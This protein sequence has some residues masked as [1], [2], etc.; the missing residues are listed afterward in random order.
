MKTS[1]HIK[2][3]LGIA[4]GVIGGIGSFFFFGE[5]AYLSAFIHYVTQP[6]GQ[7]FIRLL[8]MLVIP[9]IFSALALGV[10]G[11]GDLRRVG[12]IGLKTLIYTVAMSAIAV[13]LG[14]FLVNALA[15]GSGISDDVKARLLAGAAERSAGLPSTTTAPRTGIDLF[16][17]IIPDNPI[18]AAA[19]G[20]MLAVMFFSLMI[21]I[22]LALSRA[23][24]VARFREFLEG[25]YEATMRLIT[26]VISSKNHHD[27][28]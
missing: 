25:L 11:L 16:I 7:I 19:N 15:P 8:F 2:M 20:D 3:L 27:C 6:V 22:G 1:L 18:R 28:T 13:L 14:V 4:V 10:A 12:R 5:H 17:Q 23:D 21:G 9:L 26:L 24:K